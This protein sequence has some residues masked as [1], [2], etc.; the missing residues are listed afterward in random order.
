MGNTLQPAGF[1][2]CA[3]IPTLAPFMGFRVHTR[4][5]QWGQDPCTVLGCSL[6]ELFCFD[7]SRGLFKGWARLWFTWE[8]SRGFHWTG[9]SCGSAGQC[10]TFRSASLVCCQWKCPGPGRTQFYSAW[11]PQ[12]SKTVSRVVTG[13]RGVEPG[14]G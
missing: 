5:E 6:S 10:L 11:Q 3:Q 4:Q 1:V 14:R 2:V 13:N 8:R 12:S 9:T 7:A